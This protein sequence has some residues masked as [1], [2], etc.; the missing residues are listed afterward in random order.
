MIPA[1]VLHNTPDDA[2]RALSEGYFWRRK[3]ELSLRLLR[4]HCEFAVPVASPRPIVFV[5]LGCGWATDLLFFHRTLREFR[6][7][8]AIGHDWHFIGIDGDVE[9]LGEAQRR[10]GDTTGHVEWIRGDFTHRIPLPDHAADVLYCSEVIEHMDDPMPFIAEWRRVLRP[11]GVILVTTPNEPNIF[12]PSFYSRRRRAANRQA[13][14][15]SPHQV[16]DADGHVFSVYGHIGIRRIDEWETLFRSRGLQLVDFERGALFYSPY[17]LNHRGIFAVQ[18]V[19]EAILD[20][21][22][23]RLTRFVS[24][25]LIGLY[26][27]G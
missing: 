16:T 12:Q 17:Y 4:R 18:R 22:P 20:V 23:K 3:R 11:G 14:L 9:K 1:P 6:A 15:D 7:T 21:L 24:D 26:R 13:L 8:G 10:I 5:D 27:T 2:P 25:Q 19:A